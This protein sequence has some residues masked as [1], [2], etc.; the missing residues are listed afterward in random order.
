MGAIAVV[1]FALEAKVEDT[2][3][4][5]MAGACEMLK[6]SNCALVGGHSCEGRELSLGFSI[7]GYLQKDKNHLQKA[8]MNVGDLLIVTKAIGTGTIF[9]A[10]MRLQAKATW[11][12]GAIESMTVS[13]RKA[14]FCLRD[15]GSTSCTDI[16]GFGLLGHLTE[17][18]KASNTCVQVNL[19]KIPILEGALKCVERGIF[20]SL[21][22]ANLRV[23]RTIA[24]EAEA[25]RRNH[26]AYPL[27]FDPQTAGGLLASVPKNKAEQCISELHNLGYSCSVVIGEV[28]AKTDQVGNGNARV[29][30]IWED[31][32][33]EEKKIF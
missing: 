21:Q 29:E 5:M 9:A 11:I 31:I 4:Q 13:N 23:K 33:R 12:Q 14:A 20:S 2:L 3:Y 18:T 7:N 10:E 16:T 22:P 25:L 27:L 28:V 1:P 19:D 8:G 26:K 17:M 32:D 6:E 30:L 24:N 15:H